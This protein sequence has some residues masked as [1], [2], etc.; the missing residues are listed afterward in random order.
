M[1]ICLSC[2]QVAENTDAFCP[3]CGKPL[4]IS[5]AAS[6]APVYVL[7]VPSSPPPSADELPAMARFGTASLLGM[8]AFLVSTASGVMAIIYLRGAILIN[9]TTHTVKISSNVI[10]LLWISAGVE[11]VSL[12]ILIG[13]LYH[14]RQVFVDLRARAS[15][16]STPATLSGLAMAGAA[17][18]IIGSFVE[19]QYTAGL[20]GCLN[21]P[22]ATTASC[23][24]GGAAVASLGLVGLAAIVF[25]IGLIGVL[26]GVWRIGVRYRTELPRIG[27]V[28]SIFPYVNWIGM[29]LNYLGAAE[30]RSRLQGAGASGSGGAG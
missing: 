16:F 25:F 29:L 7:Q 11:A 24:G 17:L 21:Q 14:Y 20:I 30:I 13:S 1:K 19:V 22:G 6:P 28:L 27:S 26:I 4:P 18:L 8:I 10:P 5:A 2:G 9:T 12:A 15:T 23:A 3:R